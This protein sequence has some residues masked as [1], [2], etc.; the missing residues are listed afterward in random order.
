MRQLNEKVF[1]TFPVLKAD[2]L[3]MRDIRPEDAQQIYTMRANGRVN[4]FIPRPN[5]ETLEQSQEL[6]DRTIQAYNN[7]QAIGWAGILRDGRTIIGTCGF[8]SIEFPN[9]RAEIGGE[10][11]IEYWGKG[12]AQEAVKAIINFGFQTLGLHTIEAKVAPDNRGSVY[13]L[14]LLGFHK[15]AHFRDRGRINGVFQDMAVYTLFE[16]DWKMN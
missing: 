5:M 6:I 4:Q 12:I 16:E 14:E 10:L 7:R 2:R 1:E 3:T 15:E 13:I 11:A 9:L 8:N